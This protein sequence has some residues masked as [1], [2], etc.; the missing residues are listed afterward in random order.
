MG[1][2]LRAQGS[3]LKAQGS[4]TTVPSVN[5]TQDFVTTVPSV[6]R[7]QDFVLRAQRQ[8]YAPLLVASGGGGINPTAMWVCPCTTVPEQQ[9]HSLT[10]TKHKA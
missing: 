7:T 3:E 2:E 8:S 6:N 1:V 10:L 9:R 5:R 4:V